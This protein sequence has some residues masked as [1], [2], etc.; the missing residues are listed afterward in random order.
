MAHVQG[1]S[2]VGA[3]EEKKAR[4]RF[5]VDAYGERFYHVVHF[6]TLRENLNYIPSL[7][8]ICPKDSMLEFKSE[9]S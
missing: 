4:L 2:T 7:S 6:A 1:I 3:T 9:I 8:I 5:C